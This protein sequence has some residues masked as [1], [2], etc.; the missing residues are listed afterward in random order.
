LI[1]AGRQLKFRPKVK[2]LA[3]KTEINGLVLAAAVLVAF[4]PVC[5]SPLFG[6]NITRSFLSPADSIG[7]SSLSFD[8]ILNT[9]NWSGDVRKNVQSGIWTA[10]ILQHVGSRVIKTGWTA[11]QDEYQG[12]FSVRARLSDKWNLR[13]QDTSIV[14]ADNRV[15]DLGKLAQHQILSGLEYSPAE[16][17]TAKAA[18]GYE[19]NFQEEEHDK[20]F[21]CALGM[22]GRGIKFE[23]FLTSFHSSWNQSS[24][25]R[26]SPNTG[27]FRITLVR[28]FGE[29]VNDSIGFSYTTQRREFYTVI[30]SISQAALGIRHNIFRRTANVME[31]TNKT[32]Y[33]IG[34]SFILTAKLGLTNNTIDRGDRFK[35]YSHPK[36]VTL[37]SRIQEN[38]LFASVLLHIQALRWLNG[39]LNF[40]YMEE[41]EKH[42]VNDDPHVPDSTFRKGLM[43][44]SRLENSAQ[45]TAVTAGIT[46]DLTNSDM[47]RLV[48]SANILRYDTPDPLNVDDRDELLLMFSAE[49]VH[50]FSPRLILSLVSDINLFHLVYLNSS[51]S[52]N[53]NWNRVVRLSPSVE[54]SPV[55]WF[56]TV[57]RTEVMANYT[58]SDY[59]QQVSSVRSFSFRQALWSDSSVLQVNRNIRFNFSGTLRIF[60]RGTLKWQ[61]FKERP[62]EYFIEKAVWPEIVC[63]WDMG[64]T[65]GIG[66]R[67]FGQDRYAYQDGRRVFSGDMEAM[68]PTASLEWRGNSREIVSINGWLEEQRRKGTRTNII[69]NLSIQTR[70]IL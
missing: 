40:T 62:E 44:A 30:D 59:E 41:E 26:R 50:Y 33:R 12:L 39:D 53:N 20:G 49:A 67:Y 16:N 52:A 60:E 55:Y 18:G 8:R 11:I 43:S 70:F 69:S 35:D 23:E 1:R 32:T 68:G 2:I 54:Y 29:G 13:F 17:I 7:L 24:L 42:L 28:D 19:L 5:V 47:V 31:I 66:Y 45:R 57:A 61:E 64:L 9:Y 56:R 6:Q 15:I 4:I 10:N 3:M 27:D 21:A 25:G 48:S 46:A 58:V 63:S 22:D 14:L 38:Q 51:Q 36:L 34:D 37:D 65:L